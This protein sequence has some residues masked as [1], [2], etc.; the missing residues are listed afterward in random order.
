MAIKAC[1]I[2]G[3]S[4][5]K[6]SKCLGKLNNA[7][8]RLELVKN[9][10]DGTKVFIDFAHTPDAITTAINALKDHFKKNNDSFWLWW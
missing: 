2:L 7:K 8:G 6:I 9:F 4:K 3:L 1:E 10:P 5:N